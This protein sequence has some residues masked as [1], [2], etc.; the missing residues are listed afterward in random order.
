MK[1]ETSLNALYEMIDHCMQGRENPIEQRV[2]NWVL[3]RKRTNK[4]FRL[5]VQIGEYDVD[6]IILDL[7]YNVNVFP[8]RPRILWENLS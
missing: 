1:Y 5:S 3:H 6:N 4:E 8:N 2:V 7:G